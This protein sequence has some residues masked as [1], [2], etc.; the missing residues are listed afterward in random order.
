MT[1]VTLRNLGGSVVMVVPKQILGLLHLDAGSQV[2][3]AVEDGRLVVSP[4]QKP[5]YTLSELLAQCTVKNMAPTKEDR[6]WL[7][8]PAVGKELP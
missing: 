8:A 1:S 3:V 2:D 4:R 5:R 7:N 6:A